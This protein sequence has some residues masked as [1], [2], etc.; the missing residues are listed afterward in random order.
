M[1]KGL[2]LIIEDEADS[3][4]LLSKVVESEGFAVK[5]V[6][7]SKQAFKIL[8]EQEV[9][10]ILSDVNL[11]DVNGLQLIEKFKE[12][13]P[14]AEVIMLTAFGSVKDGVQ[15]IKAGA[16]DYLIKG[17]DN[18]RLIP[19]LQR[20]IEKVGLQKR[21]KNLEQQV[22]NQY[23]FDEIIGK[24]Q[25]IQYAIHMAKQ[26]AATSATVLLLGD[27]GTGKEVFARAIHNASSRAS[28]SFVAINCSAFS[29]ELL[30]SELFGHKAGSFTGATGDKKG[31]F[32]EAH[33]GTIFLD[34]IGE[35]PLDLQ[36]KLLRVLET[37]TFIKVGD[38]KTTQ[39]D[40][41]IIAATN[42]RLAKA[43]SQQFRSDL[44][45]RLSV[46]EI[47]LPPLRERREDIPLLA[48]SFLHY[49]A[50]NTQKKIVGMT[51][52]FLEYLSRFTWKGNIR[53]LRNVIERAVI[54]SQGPLLDENVLPFEVK[55]GPST[56][57]VVLES[58]QLDIAFVERVHIQRVMRIAGGNKAKAARLLNI[59]VSTLY[60]KLVEYN[61]QESDA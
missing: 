26:V 28:R 60:R 39:V 14:E 40:V 24:S 13:N 5:A 27:T 57:D 4:L 10:I 48:E 61:L 21:L 49:F 55:Y 41:R 43:S 54:L 45:Y 34:E 37:N 51:D 9:D 15:A 25:E 22:G 44:Y 8:K 33:E 18:N 6:E 58:N 32:E 36:A 23:T 59:G 12:I 19:M 56:E 11:A 16:Y 38:T 35:M 47:N 52:T 1:Q 50:R 2:I 7:T 53:E 20:A 29:K 46:F 30:E 17:D 42:R 3:R 31:L